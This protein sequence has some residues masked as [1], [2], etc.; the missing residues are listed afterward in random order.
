M[1]TEG[2]EMLLAAKREWIPAKK[3]CASQHRELQFGFPAA[4]WLRRRLGAVP[5]PHGGA[6]GD[7]CRSGFGEQRERGAR[8]AALGAAAPL[9]VPLR[10]L[11]RG[12]HERAG[13]A[14]PRGQELFVPKAWLLGE[15][16]G[17]GRAEGRGARLCP[18]SITPGPSTGRSP[19][20]SRR[21]ESGPGFLARKE[22]RDARRDA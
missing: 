14:R 8:L 21:A 7:G 2:V 10:L 18:Q 17:A 3:T 6:G 1:S 19:E 12:S 22:G 20:A 16:R 4:A 15:R 9:P 5:K 13:A 11:Y